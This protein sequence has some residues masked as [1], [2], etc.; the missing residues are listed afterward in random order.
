MDGNV[1]VR[2]LSRCK[3]VCLLHKPVIL[4]LT[5]ND[6]IDTTEILNESVT[7]TLQE[8]S[9]LSELKSLQVNLSNAMLEENYADCETRYSVTNEDSKMFYLIAVYKV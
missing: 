7:E 3:T 6:S 5:D 8:H 2:L 9:I 4:L 1:L